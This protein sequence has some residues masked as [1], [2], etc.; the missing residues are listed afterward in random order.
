MTYTLNLRI[1]RGDKDGGAVEDFDFDPRQLETLFAELAPAA[2][3]S[4]AC[5]G[6][7]IPP[8]LTSTS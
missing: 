7:E 4:H 2:M 5:C 8:T 6:V 3:R 1:W